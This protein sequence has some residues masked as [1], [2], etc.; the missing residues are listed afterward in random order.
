MR[1]EIVVK[2]YQM[3]EKLNN[4]IVKKVNKLDK[5]FDEEARCKI[6]LK[7]EGKDSKMEIQLDYKGAFIRAQAYAENFYDALDM[8]LPKLERQIYKQRTKLEK[9][10]VAQPE[11]FEFEGVE[12]VDPKLV[13][14]K[15]FDM[16]PMSVDEAIE[17][18]EMIGHTF[19]VFLE[20]DSNK[21][22]VLYLRDDGNL[23]L[24]EPVYNA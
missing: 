21:I 12:T 18:F 15:R 11:A 13:K 16:R 17:E 1:I 3:G 5:Y 4:I 19:Y 2:N 9:Q 8:V 7:N 24:I 14:T 20:Q 10:R 6:Y 22:K 23:G